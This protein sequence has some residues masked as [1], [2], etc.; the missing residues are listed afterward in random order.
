ME[1]MA[2][3]FL[4]LLIGNGFLCQSNCIRGSKV[5]QQIKNFFHDALA[6]LMINSGLEI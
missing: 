5:N 6:W 4:Q 3:V 2:S 1:S